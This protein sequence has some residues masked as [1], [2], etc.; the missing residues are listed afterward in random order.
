MTTCYRTGGDRGGDRVAEMLAGLQLGLCGACGR[1]RYGSRR[2]ARHAARV[3][4]PGVRLRAYR[5]G[6][7]WHLTSPG[8]PQFIAP[9]VTVLQPPGPHWRRGLDRR[10]GDER[11]YRRSG[12]QGHGRPQDVA[13]R[14]S[15]LDDTDPLEDA[16]ATHT[17]IRRRAGSG[18][19]GGGVR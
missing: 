19:G 2:Q 6:R 11:A 18:A 17:T 7:A 9:P 10:G 4:A 13:C 1:A 5:C 3:A 8:A 16:H 12:L 14:L 15:H